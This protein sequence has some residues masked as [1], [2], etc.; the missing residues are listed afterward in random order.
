VIISHDHYDH[1]TYGSIRNLKIR[2]RCF[3][4]PIGGWGALA[5]MGVEKERIVEL[6]WWQEVSQRRF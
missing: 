2:L 3:K 1:W 6:D 5:K 4:Y